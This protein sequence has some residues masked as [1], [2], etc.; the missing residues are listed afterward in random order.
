MG[1]VQFVLLCPSHLHLPHLFGTSFFFLGT[2][3][4]NVLYQLQSTPTTNNNSSLYLNH[5][6]TLTENSP[7]EGIMFFLRR[8]AGLFGKRVAKNT[9]SHPL[10]CPRLRDYLQGISRQHMYLSMLLSCN[11]DQPKLYVAVLF[12]LLQS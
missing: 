2:C 10:E 3:H 4:N 9:L 1:L 8:P 6:I 7:V 5:T 11:S 12:H